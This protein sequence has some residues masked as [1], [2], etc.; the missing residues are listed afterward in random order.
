MLKKISL[1]HLAFGIIFG[2]FLLFVYRSFDA[3][4]NIP[5]NE[6]DEAHRA[7]N[8]RR[9]AEYNSWFVPITGSV[10]DR[11]LDFRIPSKE[12]PSKFLYYHLERP[13]LIYNLM[14]LSSKVFGITEFS[15]RFPS[16]ILGLLTIVGFLISCKLNSKKL[17]LP[18][19]ILGL[20]CLMTSADL[21][22]S[23]QYAQLDTGLTFFLFVSLVS[24]M[25]FI[26]KG[27]EIFLIT[28]S[29]GFALAVLSKGQ[30]AILLLPVILFLLITKKVDK[31]VLVK[32]IG[33]STIFL[34]PWISIIS[35]KFGFINFTK[36]F[37]G[38]TFSTPSLDIAH[39]SAPVFWYTRWLWESLRPGWALFLSLF[40][41]DL[42]SKRITWQKLTLLVFILGNLFWLSLLQNKL[43]WYILPLIP[44][45]CLY[46]YLSARDYLND[47]KYLSNIAIVI[48][49][50]SRSPLGLSNKLVLFYGA[51]FT[52]VSFYILNQVET[53]N[54][55]KRFPR[56]I[57]F[58]FS[59]KMLFVYAVTLSLF[60][61][62]TRFPKI[63]P[64]HWNIKTI[65]QYFDALPKRKCLWI[66]QIPTES[67]LFY[68]NTQE[69][70]TYNLGASPLGHCDN[71]I[72]TTSKLKD[73]KLEYWVGNMEL[74]KF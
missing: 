40:L 60:F 47:E 14:M 71:Y 31:W 3:M 38:F 24:L 1:T 41:T 54:I 25:I 22:E 39:H 65:S 45:I 66:Y 53:L 11:I 29:L 17:H 15:Y 73:F 37:V 49:I 26:E 9:M 69:V 21:W 63:I 36:I 70:Y 13:P 27:R 16:F 6:F 23:S 55:T 46:I 12:D 50:L 48:M 44:P 5:F 4:L 43:W 74:Y 64:Y 34:I 10:Q 20:I 35:L 58:I 32:F 57:K 72:M 59:P 28:A 8:A 7:E 51:L 19:F 30:P 62:Y 67:V 2:F 33:Y 42:I 18:A 61:F 52:S 56:V 68:S